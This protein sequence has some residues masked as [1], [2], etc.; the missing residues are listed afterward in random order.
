LLWLFLSLLMGAFSA[1]L[2]AMIGGRQ[3]DHVRPV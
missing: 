2:A 3:R 1:S